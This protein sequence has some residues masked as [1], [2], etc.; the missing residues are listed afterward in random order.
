MF[1]TVWSID[2]AFEDVC[3]VLID[4]EAYPTWWPEVR[5]VEDLGGGRFDMVARSLLPF[6]LHTLSEPD[7]A[8]HEAGVIFARLCGDLSGIARWTVE[9]LGPDCRV[10]YDQEV[11]THTLVLNRLAPIARPAFRLSHRLMMRH[12]QA[13]LRTYMAGH[14]AGRQ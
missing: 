6:E 3:A 14:K 11:E 13:G 1:H 12:G 7:G 10:V 5:S 8:G 2:A 9:A 4:V